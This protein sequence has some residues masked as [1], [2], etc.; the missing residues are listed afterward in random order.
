MLVSC[1]YSEESPSAQLLKLCHYS[2]SIR[3]TGVVFCSDGV[4][5]LMRLCVM[6]VAVYANSLLT[7]FD[8]LFAQIPPSRLLIRG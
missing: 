5:D 6:F 8:C 4:V 1:E 7:D 3:N 2:A